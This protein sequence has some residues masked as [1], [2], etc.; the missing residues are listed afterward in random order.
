MNFYDTDRAKSMLE[1]IN[2]SKFEI[3][4][5]CPSCKRE[6]NGYPAIYR[7]DNKTEICSECRIKEAICNFLNMQK[8]E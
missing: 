8:A 2:D 7:R 1:D 4:E 6:M 5:T 3:I